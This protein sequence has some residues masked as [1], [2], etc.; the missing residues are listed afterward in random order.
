MHSNLEEKRLLGRHRCSG[1][2]I[3]KC[4]TISLWGCWLH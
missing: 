4:I 3:L 2:T 1:T